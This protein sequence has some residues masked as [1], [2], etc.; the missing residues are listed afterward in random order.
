[1]RILSKLCVVA[2]LMATAV[3]AQT[4]SRT[5]G[6]SLRTQEAAHKAGPGR[7]LF[8]APDVDHV[9]PYILSAGNWTTTFYLT[10]LE[11]RKITVDC[12]FVGPNGEELPLK[13]D[14]LKGDET[15]G[16]TTSSIPALSSGTFQTVSTATALTTAWAYCVAEPRTDRFSGYAVVKN[17]ATNGATREFITTLQPEAEPVFSVPFTDAAAGRTALILINSAIEEDS[18]LAIFAYDSQGKPAGNLTLTLKAGNLRP[19]ILND[20][21]KD[22][23]SGTLRVVRVDGAKS[24]T[25]L[26]LR[27]NAAGYAAFTPLTPKEALPA[28]PVQ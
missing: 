2:I 21:F 22:L 27:T 26:A 28:P 12:E 9:F 3:T 23:T 8:V 17:I 25:G 4:V 13:F 1:M 20:T 16:F 6:R 19:I 15:T 18:S 5:G 24:I 7:Q 14:F 11:D 10:N